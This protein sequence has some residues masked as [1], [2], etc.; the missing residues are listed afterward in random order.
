MKDINALGSE[1]KY[2]FEYLR[3]DEKNPNEIEYFDKNMKIL[4]VFAE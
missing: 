1:F 4:G 3:T 2:F